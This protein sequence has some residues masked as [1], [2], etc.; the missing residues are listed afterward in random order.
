MIEEGRHW[1]SNAHFTSLDR[2]QPSYPSSTYLNIYIYSNNV[3]GNVNNVNVN[4]LF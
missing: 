1:L 3:K 2:S 4:V